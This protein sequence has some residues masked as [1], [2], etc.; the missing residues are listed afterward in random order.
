[1][2]LRRRTGAALA[3]ALFALV[4]IAAIAEAVL[5]PALAS[6]TA[7]VRLAAHHAAE[8]GA[9]RRIFEVV[10][11]WSIARWQALDPA[12]SFSDTTTVVIGSL[13]PRSVRTELHVRR[14]GSSVFHVRVRATARSAPAH[15]AVERSVLVELRAP[16]PVPAVAVTAGGGVAVAGDA[17]LATVDDCPAAAGLTAHIH[18]SPGA[19][20]SGAGA[21]AGAVVATRDAAASASITYEAPAGLDL[22]RLRAA[23]SVRPGIGATV[24]PHAVVQ[25]ELCV[26]SESNWGS[27]SGPCSTRHVVVAVDGDLRIDGGEGQGALVVTGRLTIDGPFVFR[28]LIVASGGLVTS[29]AVEV[30]GAVFTSP[31]GFVTLGEGGAVIRASACALEP[32]AAAIPTLV[33]VRQRGWWR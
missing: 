9:E 10:G 5:Q 2:T 18:T 20:V 29:G 15:A 27:G 3:A 7:A 19:S 28:G 12:G 8:S 22:R 17:A 13:P 6:R 16:S 26:V 1:M 11:S 30:T 25:D 33:V 21:G 31:D 14:L 23:A 32:A 4:A 24:Q